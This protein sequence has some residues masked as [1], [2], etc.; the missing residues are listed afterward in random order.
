MSGRPA[1]RIIKNGPIKATGFDCVKFAGKRLQATGDV[2]LCRCGRSS[3]APFCDGT[4]AKIG[5]SGAN[6]QDQPQETT[7]WEGKTIRTYFNANICMHARMCRPLKSL[8]ERELDGDASAAQQIA[9]VVTECP[10]GALTYDMVE[11]ENPFGF[12]ESTEIDIV[13]GGE[14]RIQCVAD[15]EGVELQDRQPQNRMTLCRCGLSKNK[16]FCDASHAARKDF[17]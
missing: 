5:F 6:E 3:N 17:K 10:S 16:P 2:F 12:D 7:G 11:G 13:E 8:R 9:K 15:T 1:I 4:H 14:I